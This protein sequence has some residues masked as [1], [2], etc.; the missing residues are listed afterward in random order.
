MELESIR[1]FVQDHP[2][3]VLIRMIDGTV[4]PIPHRDWISFG[5]PVKSAAGRDVVRGTPFIIYEEPGG[6]FGMRLVN[7]MM[8]ADVSPMKSNGN[9]HSASNGNGSHD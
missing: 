6:V 2:D 3:G 4:Y 5:P 7:A 9:G 1:K 8:V